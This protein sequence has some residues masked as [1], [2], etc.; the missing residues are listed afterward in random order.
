MPEL[1]A[2]TLP[3]FDSLGLSQEPFAVS[4]LPP[5]TSL[6]FPCPEGGCRC[7]LSMKGCPALQAAL[8]AVVFHGQSSSTWVFAPFPFQ[9]LTPR[10]FHLLALFALQKPPSARRLRLFARFASSFSLPPLPAYPEAAAFASVRKKRHRSSF[11][12]PPAF[13]LFGDFRS[14]ASGVIFPLRRGIGS[15]SLSAF[16]PFRG[17]VALLFL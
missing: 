8:R 12:F 9:H 17:T 7:L 1:H 13:F 16:C 4:S 15:S 3:A 10:A 2:P 6:L 14:E 5:Q 11:F